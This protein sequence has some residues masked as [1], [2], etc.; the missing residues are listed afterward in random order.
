VLQW[1]ARRSAH[2]R[3]A[4]A[5]TEE[6]CDHA[7][8]ELYRAFVAAHAEAKHFWNTTVLPDGRQRAEWA[9]AARMADGSVVAVA[10]VEYATIGPD[11]RI[12][13]LRNDMERDAGDV[14]RLVRGLPQ[15]GVADVDAFR[16]R[17]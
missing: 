6:C 8:R 13:E 1:A 5:S 9:C 16:M 11:D 12:V 4:D 10:G 2:L 14:P 17:R 15:D 3:S 7:L